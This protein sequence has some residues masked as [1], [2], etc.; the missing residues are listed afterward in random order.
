MK[1]IDTGLTVTTTGSSETNPIPVP[2][3]A[4]TAKFA[5]FVSD[6]VAYL[7]LGGSGVDATQNDILLTIAP[8]VLDV[9]T[10]THFAVIWAGS[11]SKVNCTPVRP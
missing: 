4:R 1:I 6:S 10:T 2:S 7:K 11:T 8:I 5:R 9:S 3:G